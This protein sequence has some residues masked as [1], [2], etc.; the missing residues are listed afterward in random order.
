MI[1]QYEI[2]INVMIH[3]HEPLIMNQWFIGRDDE[4]VGVA[5]QII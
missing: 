1:P 4:G 2:E 3:Y 5:H